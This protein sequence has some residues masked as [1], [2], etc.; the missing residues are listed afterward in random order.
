MVAEK[1]KKK[2]PKTKFISKLFP[3]RVPALDLPSVD[4]SIVLTNAPRPPHRRES[5][6]FQIPNLHLPQPDLPLPDYD[7]P[8]VNMRTGQLPNK[9]EFAVPK[10]RLPI[11]EDLTLPQTAN[12]PVRLAQNELSE[13]P[14]PSPIGAKPQPLTIE[15]KYSITDTRFVE[16]D[17]DVSS[18]VR[19]TNCCSDRVRTV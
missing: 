3:T 11:I 9:D 17:D 2:K 12:K 6:P 4:Q 1:A 19:R 13:V 5:D 16:T 7:R 10:V 14:F 18:F 15:E 8:E